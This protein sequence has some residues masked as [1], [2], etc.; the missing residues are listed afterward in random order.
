ML[1]FTVSSGVQPSEGQAVAAAIEAGVSGHRKDVDI[2]HVH[3]ISVAHVIGGW[4]ATAQVTLE[5]SLK[6]DIDNPSLQADKNTDESKLEE[7]VITPSEAAPYQDIRFKPEGFIY[8]QDDMFGQNIHL[9][10]WLA[11]S[12]DY[13]WYQTYSEYDHNDVPSLLP[14]IPYAW[15]SIE[16]VLTF[17]QAF[18]A[19]NG[20]ETP[21]TIIEPRPEPV[22]CQPA[23]EPEPELLFQKALRYY[24][25]YERYGF[26][27]IDTISTPEPSVPEEN[28]APTA[29]MAAPTGIKNMQP[30]PSPSVHIYIPDDES[31]GRTLYDPELY[32]DKPSYHFHFMGS[33]TALWKASR[34]IFP[35][36]DLYEA[37]HYREKAASDPAPEIEIKPNM[38]RKLNPQHCYVPE[39]HYEEG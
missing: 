1:S 3:V 39:P 6:A 7:E 18:P 28:T 16:R 19:K 17:D 31:I 13:S 26:P 27:I 10:L 34:T 11:A 32:L 9:P 38:S 35:D 21:T 30:D 23:D 33:D 2:V 4:M 25:F 15:S 12:Y 22:G 29:D 8:M 37:T 24:T 5:L 14:T 20:P 36:V